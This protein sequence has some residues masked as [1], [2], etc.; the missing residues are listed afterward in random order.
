M[1]AHF[2]DTGRRVGVVAFLLLLLWL[3][4]GC[5]TSQPIPDRAASTDPTGPYVPV[6][7]RPDSS[8]TELVKADK[9]VEKPYSTAPKRSLL[10]RITGKNKPARQVAS[11]GMPAKCKG[12]TFNVVAG[13]QTN[14]TAGKNATAGTGAT[15]GGK[16]SAPV[17]G[18]GGSAIEKAKAPVTTGTGDATDQSGAGVA[19]TIKGDNNAPKLTNT[20]PEAPGIGATIASNLTKPLGVVVALAVVGLFAY[21]CWRY[22]NRV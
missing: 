10:D 17:A 22:K 20:A 13:N 5:R 7:V 12:C 4:A 9:L 21:G 2:N 8:A 11:T 16:A 6:V 14:N 15:G 19:S 1:T 18:A 3:L